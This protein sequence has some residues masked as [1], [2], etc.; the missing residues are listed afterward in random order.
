[1]LNT[2]GKNILITGGNSGLGFYSVINLLKDKNYIF[3]PIKSIQRKHNFLNKLYQYFEPNFLNNYLNIINEVDLSDL[4]NI[5]KIT[6]FLESE[7]IKLDILIL[8]AGIQYTGSRYPKVSRQGIELTFAVNHLSHFVLTNNLIP[9]MRIGPGKRIIVT[10]SDVHDPIS[11]GGNI[12]LKAGLDNLVNFKE[13]IMGQFINFNA[14]KSYKNSK[15]CNILFAKEL[16]RILEKRQ[17]EISIITWAPGLVIPEDDLGFFR[18]SSKF[19]KIGYQIFATLANR[20]LGI[21]ENVKDAGDLLYSIVME[22][23]FNDIK[24]VH[25]SNRLISYRKHKLKKT[26]VSEEA[27]DS[28]LSKKLWDLSVEICDSF[29]I[30]LV[31]I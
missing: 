26:N 18:Y 16:S 28:C 13:E 6:N 7:N 3:I 23:D 10:S 31:D 19:N 12:G 2:S 8:N 20:I 27:N 1:M 17:M 4:K 21:S 9:F 22:K 24:Y 15:L 14:D 25:L 30:T 11:P 29:K 5:K